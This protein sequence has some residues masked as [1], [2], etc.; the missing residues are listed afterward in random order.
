MQSDF[1]D[2]LSRAMRTKNMKQKDL[3]KVSGVTE[4]TISRYVNSKRHP[5]VNFLR[6]IVPVLGVSSDY[7]LGFTDVMEPTYGKPKSNG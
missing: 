3:S 5:D 1:G 6:K 2:R 4:A 7:L